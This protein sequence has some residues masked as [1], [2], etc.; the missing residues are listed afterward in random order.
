MMSMIFC[1]DIVD[2]MDVILYL[3]IDVNVYDIVIYLVYLELFFV[4]LLLGP[5]L[6]SLLFCCNLLCFGCI[7]R[8]IRLC[9]GCNFSLCF[10]SWCSCWSCW[11]YVLDAVL[12]Y[13][14]GPGVIGYMNN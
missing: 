9:F 8:I 10:W 4:I 14:F 13:V 11:C 6:F 5:G 3:A 1:I 7:F 2:V 12:V